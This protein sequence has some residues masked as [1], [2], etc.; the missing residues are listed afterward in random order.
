MGA[1]E[2]DTPLRFSVRPTAG[3]GRTRTLGER[4]VWAL[5]RRDWKWPLADG[6]LL[7]TFDP[8][9]PLAQYKRNRSA[10][11]ALRLMNGGLVTLLRRERL[12]L[13]KARRSELLA[14]I[15]A[16]EHKPDNAAFLE[17]VR[18]RIS[19]IEQDIADVEMLRA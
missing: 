4:H 8:F 16:F 18:S 9:L 13:L 15:S 14:L 12:K 3:L 19:T 10:D 2:S 17:E 7:A 11:S 1:C 5:N 6:P